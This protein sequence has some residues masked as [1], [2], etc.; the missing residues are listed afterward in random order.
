[1]YRVGILFLLGTI[2]PAFSACVQQGA[3]FPE[4]NSNS[5]AFCLVSSAYSNWKKSLYKEPG[6]HGATI[7][8]YD[9]AIYSEQ[10]LSQYY[11]NEVAAGRLVMNQQNGVDSKW[12]ATQKLQLTYCVSDTFAARKPLVVQAMADAASAW[13]NAG[14]VKYIYMPAEDASC[15]P[16]NKKVLFNVQ[17]T[18]GGGYL[19]RAFF[20][21]APRAERNIAIDDSAFQIGAPLTLAGILRH[22]L[23]HTLGFRH[24]HTRP[25]AGKCYEDS[26]WRALSPYDS[27]SV[28]HYPQCNGTGDWSLTLTAYDIAGTRSVYSEPGA[29]LADPNH[30]RPFTVAGTV[31]GLAAGNSLDLQNNQYD[32]ISVAGNGAYSFNSQSAPGTSYHVTIARQPAGQ[33]CTVDNG[34]G[35]MPAAGPVIITVSCV[36]T[37]SLLNPSCAATGSRS[38]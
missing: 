30:P 35:V 26:N 23:G 7:V 1:M 15:T 8:D 20:P 17:P 16:L 29:S 38:I 9:R 28:M 2:L 21:F 18:S 6:E 5:A 34:D 10:E 27:S 31:M 33:L 37:G 13:Q 4:N 12:S 19:A 36:N 32:L 14:D 25:E 3:N 11:T 22:E 24:E